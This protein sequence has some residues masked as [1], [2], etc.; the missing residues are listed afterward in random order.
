MQNIPM[1]ANDLEYLEN[2]PNFRTFIKVIT[3]FSICQ[4]Y[5]YID[6]IVSVSPNDSVNAFT[7]FR[8]LMYSHL[9]N[10][11]TTLMTY[12]QEA[13]FCIKNT[14]VCIEK[15][16]RAISRFFTHGLGDVGR[17]FY[18]D[19]SDFI[20]LR[21]EK[22]GSLEYTEK[23]K[24]PSDSYKPMNQSSIEF[25]KISL[26]AKSK[27]L[28]SKNYPNWAFTVDAVK[29]YAYKKEVSEYYFVQIDGKIYALT[30]HTSSRYKIPIYYDTDKIKPKQYA[31]YLIDEA[32]LL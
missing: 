15:G 3:N 10:I 14:I 18:S 19:F 8:N 20:H 5:Y 32:K 23:K 28:Y 30:G 12:E 4:R 9:D 22:L 17:M 27:P 11:D 7:V 13:E 16:V 24:Y 21:D 1:V 25:T 29:V 31:N 2:D 6:A 26:S